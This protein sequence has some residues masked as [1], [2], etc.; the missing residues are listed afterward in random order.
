MDNGPDWATGGSWGPEGGA[1]AALGMI[2]G[3]WLLLQW[4]R[5]RAPAMDETQRVGT[6]RK[7][8]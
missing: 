3:L 7:D 6:W 1:G 5:R 4:R 8:A 2:V